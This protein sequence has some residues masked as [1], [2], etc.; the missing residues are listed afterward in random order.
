M[1]RMSICIGTRNRAGLL[2][3]HIRHIQRFRSLDFE[4]VVSDNGS[5]DDT[6]EVVAALQRDDPRIFYIRQEQ[7]LTWYESISASLALA[8]GDYLM[9]IADDDFLQEAGSLRAVGILDQHPNVAAVYGRFHPICPFEAMED[10]LDHFNKRKPRAEGIYGAGDMLRLY[11]GNWL[12]EMP[13]FRRQVYHDSHLPLPF[14]MPLDFHAM[15]RFLKFGD[16]ALINDCVALIWQHQAQN[17]NGIYRDDMIYAYLTDYE[18]FA[19]ELPVQAEGERG[20]AI[21][22]KLSTQYVW[23][24]E[25]AADDGKYL[26]GRHFML[27]AL[28][29][30]LPETRQKAAEFQKD[31][32]VFMAAEALFRFYRATRPTRTVLCENHPSALTVGGAAFEWFPQVTVDVL[33]REDL[34]DWPE[35]DEHLYLTYDHAVEDRRREV[36]GHAPRKMRAVTD[37]LRSINLFG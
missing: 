29:Y 28:A 6:R 19:S 13:I 27:K 26:L 12:L 3:R 5:E 17:S 30:R 31:N 33:E 9:F 22:Y 21:A 20:G 15:A 37:L 34:I 32:M 23:A 16:V 7:P 18:L 4:I 10:A 1:S 35:S 2:A 11:R 24:A 25:K 36:H 8:G 14:H